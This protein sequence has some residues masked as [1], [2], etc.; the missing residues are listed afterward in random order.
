MQGFCILSAQL[1]LLVQMIEI[2]YNSIHKIKNE[3]TEG[4]HVSSNHRRFG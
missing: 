1:L 3:E 4:S 2:C